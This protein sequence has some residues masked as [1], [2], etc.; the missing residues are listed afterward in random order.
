MPAA[1]LKLPFDSDDPEP[2]RSPSA[3][4]A[5]LALLVLVAGV[6]GTLA[7]VDIWRGQV[8][9]E[10]R[11]RVGR[12]VAVRVAAVR[13]GV[14][15]YENAL[16]AERAFVRAAGAVG[17]AQLRAFAESL[18]LPE[19][20]PGMQGIGFRSAGGS[21]G[22][23]V[24]GLEIPPTSYSK[25]LLRARDSGRNTLSAR[26]V[27]K[28]DRGLPKAELP[29]AF[30]LFMPVYRTGAETGTRAARRAAFLGW[31]GSAFRV[32]D[33]LDGALRRSG[34]AIGV[35]LF[36]QRPTARNLIA[37][38]PTR[39]VAGGALVKTRSLRFGGRRWQLRLAP[40][41]GAAVTA[42]GKS[43]ELLFIA[44]LLLSIMLA[45]LMLLL[46]RE[47]HARGELAD[48]LAAMERHRVARERAERGLRDR[49][50]MLS[51]VIDNNPAL[52]YI[53]DLEGRYLLYNEPFVR[54]F[55][56]RER[57]EL[58]GKLGR[59]VLLGRDDSWLDPLFA[60]A[61][62]ENDVQARSGAHVVEEHSQH[63]ALGRLSYDCVKF[64]LF[65]GYGDLYATCGVALETTERK[66]A[67]AR[68]GEAEQ[69]LKGA[70]ENAPNGMALITLDG[71]FMQ[72]NAA[73]CEITGHT[74]EH[75]EQTSV[76]AITDPGEVAAQDEVLSGLVRND[77]DQG[78]LEVRLL[79]ADT[80]A[81]W[82]QLHI[83]LL[84][85]AAAQ[86]LYFIAQIE[87]IT[88][89]R[90]AQHEL[91]LAREAAI[92]GSRLKSE[93]VANMSHEI[94]TPLNGVIGMSALLL[95]TELSAEQREYADAVQL[96]GD[97]LMSVID[98]VLDFSKIEAGKLEIENEP[99][100]LRPVVEEVASV[101]ATA[102]QARDLELMSWVDAELPAVISGDSHRVRQV[103][104]NLMTNAV[105]FTAEGEV[106]VRVTGETAGERVLLR[107]E[108]TDTGIG[109]E[110]A[111]LTRIFESFAQQDGSTSRRFGGT[112]L[113][114]AISRQLT[115]LMGG[116]IGVRSTPGEG[117]T[118]WFTVPARIAGEQLAPFRLTQFE[119]AGVLVVDDNATNLTILER[120]L[121]AWGLAC[122]T[123]TDPAAVPGL[124]HA[125]AAAGRGYRLVLIDSSMPLMSGTRLTRA[126]RALPSIHSV[127]VLML[128]SSGGGREAAADAGVDGFV[129]KPVHEARL[130]QEIARALSP[131][132]AQQQ[133]RVE[134]T[135]AANGAAR[136][137]PRVL[138]AEDNK[139]SQAVA[140]GLL[141]KR[142]FSVDVASDGREALAMYKRG[143]YELIFMDCQMPELDGFE[144][145]AEIR[146]RE[147]GERHV[148]IIAMTANTMAGDRERCLAAGM[149][150]YI[151]K[152]VRP[153]NL[154]RAIARALAGAGAGGAGLG[155]R[156]T[157]D[158]DAAGLPALLEASL[159]AGGYA[160]RRCG[161]A[162]AARA[163]R[164]PGRDDG[165]AARGG[166]R[167][168]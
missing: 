14:D 86:P 54:A 55:A 127:G 11:A 154:D 93:F 67:L 123:T 48:S 150:D 52:I 19:R 96:S 51:G 38:Y 152:P 128:T 32:Q 131:K 124:M 97:A 45:G 98:D 30:A 28:A 81:V 59:E 9:R 72:V 145:T 132:H 113:G 117:S 50:E 95:D 118:F 27:L 102:A 70:F 87:D 83:T 4:R 130:F 153:D 36:D 18:R 65:D 79:R 168:G 139:V 112:G 129:S 20:Y 74:R 149:D 23:A 34:P 21:G 24:P 104:T 167:G 42:G 114:L 73:L 26:A 119:G 58:E 76:A 99:F 78:S 29:A 122:E 63:P 105:K 35:Q 61:W 3:L 100:E 125:A 108:V 141:R 140:V 120:Q 116:E 31:A 2:M 69:R 89:R 133:V 7:V 88:E 44:G 138:V 39:F 158:G 56:L 146:G 161:A 164:R 40:L 46:G 53:K 144:V 148:P 47:R 159:L 115:E 6:L 156:S 111:S 121:S 85:G 135:P 8:E 75:L 110:A 1:L 91:G 77:H 90:R 17:P 82:T 15:S 71:R 109:I 155:D 33:F 157:P 64:P 60:P 126:I 165:R 103:L 43:A 101:V 163:V 137:G 13:A 107:F 84:R 49:Q 80:R 160:R 136:E 147:A 16:Q 151:G 37:A 162:R 41:P 66:R 25:A 22:L 57:G 106:I 10:D 62:R 68:L 166:R 134:R 143:H 5:V 92:E 12:Q 142:G 94:R